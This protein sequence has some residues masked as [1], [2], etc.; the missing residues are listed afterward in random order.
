MVLENIFRIF[1][2]HLSGSI[3]F[4]DLLIAF[5]MSIKGSGEMDFYIQRKSYHT[6]IKSHG[7]KMTFFR[8]IFKGTSAMLLLLR[9]MIR[10]TTYPI[11]Y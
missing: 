8:Q 5:S 11:M 6:E 1:D 4:T 10:E 9:L 2:P 3:R 7:L